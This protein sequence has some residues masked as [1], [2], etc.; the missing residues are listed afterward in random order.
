MKRMIFIGC[1]SLSIL[2]L[3]FC[4]SNHTT[5][6]SGII[7]EN[8]IENNIKITIKNR[9][10]DRFINR[11]SGDVCIQTEED[12]KTNLIYNCSGPVFG[13]EDCSFVIVNRWHTRPRKDGY[14]SAYECLYEHGYMYFD[15]G[16]KNM[17]LITSERQ[18]YAADSRFRN[19]VKTVSG[20]K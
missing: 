8:E 20:A 11:M 1:L 16:L 7:V 14:D 13:S 3:F 19:I 15:K 17:I 6:L 12:G 9:Q 4:F 2:I 10:I 18:V 5:N